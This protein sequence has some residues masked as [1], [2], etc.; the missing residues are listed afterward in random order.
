[1]PRPPSLR[2]HL[3]ALC[4]A[5]WL[6]AALAQ[7]PG[8][9]C[10]STDAT[11]QCLGLSHYTEPG[12]TRISGL[13]SNL[14]GRAGWSGQVVRQYPDGTRRECQADLAGRCLGNTTHY[15]TGGRRE[16][17]TMTVRA[18]V[19]VWSGQQITE[20]A[21]GDRLECRVA[22]EGLCE[23]PATLYRADGSRT[24]GQLQPQGRGHGWV[25]TIRRHF[26]NGEREECSADPAGRCR[27]TTTYTFADGTRLVGTKTVVGDRS[28][29]RG[30]VEQI[31]PSGKRMRCD[32]AAG[33]T[34]CAEDTQ[35]PVDREGRPLARL[36][37]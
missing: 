32:A 26:A 12:G 28:T 36:P 37:R 5:V 2:L 22:P 4:A 24:E 30:G 9:E 18:G 1:M 33:G 15:T 34:L 25:G 11:G 21:N 16:S 29:W 10:R 6:P 19:A 35:L 13:R 3:A 17:G 23:G 27:G 20:F 14:E 31:F 7:P 8:W